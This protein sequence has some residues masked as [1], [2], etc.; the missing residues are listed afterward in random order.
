MPD[1]KS[2]LAGVLIGGA[3]WIPSQIAV[4]TCLYAKYT[5]PIISKHQIAEGFASTKGLEWTTTG[6]LDSKHGGAMLKDD[7]V[8]YLLKRN[9]NGDLYLEKINQ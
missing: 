9:I 5:M 7:G 1:L 4:D 8:K 6:F 2:M 3:V